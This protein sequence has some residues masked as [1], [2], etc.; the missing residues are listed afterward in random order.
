MVLVDEKGD[1]LDHETAPAL[2]AERHDLVRTDTCSRHP[3]VYLLVRRN[4]SAVLPL[5]IG[6]VFSSQTLA[7]FVRICRL[8][9]IEKQSRAAEE[10]DTKSRGGVEGGHASNPDL[11]WLNGRSQGRWR[12]V[13]AGDARCP[14]SRRDG[15]ATRHFKNKVDCKLPVGIEQFGVL[16]DDLDDHDQVIIKS[17]ASEDLPNEGSRTQLLKLRHQASMLQPNILHVNDFLSAEYRRQPLN[18][19]TFEQ[20]Q[21]VKL[22]ETVRPPSLLHNSG[23]VLDVFISSFLTYNRQHP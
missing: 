11:L 3:P 1:T 7:L 14:T 5:F 10:E 18:A 6:Y 8:Q 21:S 23:M 4:T 22:G 17:R 19:K 20:H 13:S 15:T 2:T 12:M 9:S 16:V